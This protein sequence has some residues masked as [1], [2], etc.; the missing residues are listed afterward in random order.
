VWDRFYPGAA[1]AQPAAP[2]APALNRFAE[3][4]FTLD[5]QSVLAGCPAEAETLLRRSIGAGRNDFVAL[6]VLGLMAIE[7]EDFAAAEGWLR[8]VL[9]I[10]PDEPTTLNNLGEAVRRSDRLDAT[11]PCY[12][13]TIVRAPNRDSCQPPDN[14]AKYPNFRPPA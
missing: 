5:A 8:A 4:M 11:I 3:V 9:V 7:R 13:Q 6:G 2:A 12:H 14:A 1:A 10:N